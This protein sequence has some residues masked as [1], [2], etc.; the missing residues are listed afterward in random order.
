MRSLAA[1]LLVLASL[2]CEQSSGDARVESPL[3]RTFPPPADVIDPVS[4][5]PSL[6]L[7]G[8]NAVGATQFAGIRSVVADD[9]RIWLTDDQ[10][11]EIRAFAPDG[12]HVMSLGGRG[13][14]PGDSLRRGRRHGHGR[15]ARWARSGVPR[16]VPG[17]PQL[18]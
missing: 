8:S 4:A 14:G 2:S 17:A 15:P 13:D 11:Q 3:R 10:S 16:A 7:G 6:S 1:L 5:E 18:S 9:G 12:H